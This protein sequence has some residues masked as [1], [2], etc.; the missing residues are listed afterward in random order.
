[1]KKEKHPWYKP[2]GYV[3]F[4]S[5]LSLKT[6]EKLVT[7]PNTVACHAFY[8]LL[9]YTV[10]SQKIEKNPTGM[11]VKRPIKKRPISFAAHA[12]AHIYSYYGSVL[13]SLYEAR[14]KELGI[15]Q[16]V[17]AFR[18]LRKSNIH[19]AND[20][21][22]L[23]KKMGQC[24]AFATDI[25]GFFDNLEHRHLKKVWASLLG[26]TALPKDHYAV[27]K[28]L[29]HYSFVQREEVY[30]A[31]GHSDNNP[32]HFPERLC[33]APDFRGKVRGA[34]IIEKHK[35]IK[36]IPQGS[37]ISALL[38]NIYMLDFDQLL[39]AEINARGGHYMRYCDDVLCIVPTSKA[40]DL[41]AVV[42]A[43]IKRFG[44]TVNHDKTE[45][46]DFQI[47]SGILTA[48]RPLQYLGFN[49][50]G[51]R[52]LIRSAAFARFSDKMRRGV[53][54]AMQTTKKHNKSRHAPEEIWRKQLYE[55][56]SHLGKRNFV[57]YGLR[58]ARIMESRAMYRQLR[59][60]WRRLVSRIDTA[61]GKL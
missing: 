54:L 53:S 44:L 31:L 38:S 9:R 57:R 25:S 30:R 6:A 18:A 46:I 15:E 5:P 28:S 16:S 48:N 49:F 12:D 19:F 43:L 8:P 11:A 2:R 39:H 55:R 17:L 36:G 52:K 45:K 41:H 10:E 3:H 60:L 7:S 61:N 34:G 13:S 42:E 27:F 26:V 29:T 24:V 35:D 59:P 1:M 22:E 14:L 56:Y 20:A 23:I 47:H 21:F 32:P 37:P 40:A 4:D 51:T 58:A 50:D 33:S